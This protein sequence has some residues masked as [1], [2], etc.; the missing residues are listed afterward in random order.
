[1]VA[2]DKDFDDLAR[3]SGRHEKEDYVD[4]RGNDRSTYLD[5]VEEEAVQLVDDALHGVEVKSAFFLIVLP[6]RCLNCQVDVFQHGQENLT[7]Y[8]SPETQIKYL[9]SSE[10]HFEQDVERVSLVLGVLVHGQVSQVGHDG[11][12]ET[13][14]YA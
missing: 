6:A 9:D 1:M 3:L 2:L 14:H 10:Q 5:I 13:F 4:V 11:E 12:P 8:F 7:Q